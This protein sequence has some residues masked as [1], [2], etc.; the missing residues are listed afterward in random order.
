MI[1]VRADSGVFLSVPGAA[2]SGPKIGLNCHFGSCIGLENRLEAAMGP[3]HQKRSRRVSLV[4]AN[5]TLETL[6]FQMRLAKDLRYLKVDSH[7]FAAK[8]IDEIG[9]LVGGWLRSKGE[10]NP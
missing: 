8:A 9:R 5:L 10:E 2:G 1:L 3:R 4:E 7:G 6:R